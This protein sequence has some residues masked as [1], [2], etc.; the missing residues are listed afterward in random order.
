MV[1][2]QS[3]IL[4][5]SFPKTLDQVLEVEKKQGRFDIETLETAIHD[6]NELVYEWTVAK[7][8]KPD[9]IIFFMHSKSS[10]HTIVRLRNELKT[11]SWAYKPEDVAIIERALERGLK[12]YEKYGGKIFAAGRVLEMPTVTN[13]AEMGISPHWKS[14]IS[15][16]VDDCFLLEKPLDLE[17]FGK[18]IKL[19]CG[20]SITPVYGEYFERLKNMIKADNAIPAYLEESIAMPIPLM[21][22]NAENWIEVASRHRQRFL[23]ESQFRAFYVDFFLKSLGDRKKIFSECACK[24]PTIRTSFI[25]NVILFNGYYLPVEVKLAVSAEHDICG[26][27]DKYCNLDDLYLDKKENEKAP[28][29]RVYPANVLVIDTMDIYLYS[30]KERDIQKIFSLDQIRDRSDIL[31]FREKLMKVLARPNKND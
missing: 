30:S 14:R 10:N 5:L 19:S 2:V 9:D 24:K 12:V 3:L 20:G 18:F 27:V 23:Y 17:V 25:D 13:Y 29:D 15:A 7:W 21:K 22:I 4:N 1:E 8:I 16:Y 6:G 28:I 26:Q 11:M 31:L